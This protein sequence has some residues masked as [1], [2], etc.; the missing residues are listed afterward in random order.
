MMC[1]AGGDET[2]PD[3]WYSENM[4]EVRYGASESV[5]ARR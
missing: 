1:Q 5:Q 2:L 4:P 3:R